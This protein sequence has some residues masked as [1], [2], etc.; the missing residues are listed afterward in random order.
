MRK[1]WPA[2]VV[3]DLDGTLLDSRTYAFDRAQPALEAL[4]ERKIPVVLV[5][6]KTRSE[7]EEL[8]RQLDIHDPFVVENGGAVYLPKGY[9]E[10]ARGEQDVSGRFE[11]LRWGVP[12]EELVGAL[13]ETRRQTGARLEGYSDI[14]AEDVAR[15]TGL[16]L[17]EARRSM[18]REFD[19]P[20][21]VEGEE[22]ERSRRAME[23]LGARGLTVTRGG[24][25]YHIM[26]NCDKG[27][28][29]REL[30]K[31]YGPCSSAGLGDA[32]N[33]IPFLLIVDRAYIVARADGRHDPELVEAIAHARRVGPA[34]HG[35]AEA[36]LDFLSWLQAPDP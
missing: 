4:R 9:F 10:G 6:S 26:G 17:V 27:K 24:R 29:V 34:P 15:L 36:T 13:N 28:A 20:F 16:S 21:W 19:E 12:Y 1:K 35:W 25:F 5:S 31:L 33:D 30:L 32:K 8:R 18:E 2:V 7:I 22:D 14:D 11:V 23:L 3:S